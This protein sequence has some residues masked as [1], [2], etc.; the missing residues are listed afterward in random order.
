M[1][2]NLALRPY[3]QLIRF[4]KP[5]GSLLLLWPT[6]WALWLANQG[7]PPLKLLLIFILGVVLMRSAGCI[8][9]DL[10]DRQFDGHVSRTQQRPLITG[11]IT[12]TQAKQFCLLLLLAAFSLVLLTNLLT[13]GLSVVGALLALFYPY[14]KRFIH[15]PQAI[16]GLAF[17]WGVPMAFAASN[18]AVPREAWFLFI[19]AALWPVIYDT[20]YAMVDR[21]DDLKIGIYSSAILFGCYDRL[22]VAL[23]QCLWFSLFFC[24]GQWLSLPFSFT[25]GLLAAAGLAVYQQYL[26]AAREP[27]ACFRAF[28]NNHWTGLVIFVSLIVALSQ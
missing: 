12:V 20:M 26:I 28:L 27:A 13:I 11:A 8:M 5:I 6:M 7:T 22:V 19:I 3:L 14:C 17:A 16:L 15:I 23:L 2:P 21:E 1:Q 10:A 4:D 18:G 25:L 24:Y 9:N